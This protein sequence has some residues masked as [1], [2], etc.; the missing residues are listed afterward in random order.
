MS[1]DLLG[2]HP[3]AD[4][5]QAVL[6]A[7]VLLVEARGPR[8]AHVRNSASRR[9]GAGV[10]RV[11]RVRRVVDELAAVAQ[12]H[13]VQAV[14]Q[15]EQPVAHQLVEEPG[16]RR[17]VDLAVDV[18]DRVALP[19]RR[20]ADRA[21]PRRP[22]RGDELLERGLLRLGAVVA[23]GVGV[24]VEVLA[25]Q[26]A[27]VA[28]GLQPGRQRLGL[29]ALVPPEEP[30]GGVVV[31]AHAVV[32]GVLAGQDARPRRAARRL[33]DVVAVERRALVGD[34]PPGLGHPAEQLLVEVVR[35]DHDDVG[36]RGRGGRCRGSRAS[37]APR[38]RPSGPRRGRGARS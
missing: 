33:L 27:V 23:A 1:V 22:P 15:V 17:R 14:D 35:H 9:S 37:A 6:V 16:A 30:A 34:Q 20:A 2:G 12:V 13:P 36:L 26:G 18:E 5:A 10:R 3:A 7:D 19:V 29:P 32:V 28:V 4:A 21:E 38:P 25:E 24:L 31:A 8:V 11:R